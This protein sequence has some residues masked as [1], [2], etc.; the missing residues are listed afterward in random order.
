MERL[1]G[2]R[3]IRAGTGATFELATLGVGKLRKQDPKVLLGNRVEIKLGN[4]VEPRATFPHANANRLGVTVTASGRAFATFLPPKNRVGSSEEASCAGSRPRARGAE[5]L[6]EL[7]PA[8]LHPKSSC[9]ATSPPGGKGPSCRLV[10][11]FH[12]HKGETK[13]HPG[14]S[15][16]RIQSFA[17]GFRDTFPW[18]YSVSLGTQFP[19]MSNDL[20][21]LKGKIIVRPLAH[22]KCSTYFDGTLVGGNIFIIYRAPHPVTV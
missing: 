10:W 19:H 20:S 9:G 11:Q 15:L 5:T 22:S 8:P 17:L 6:A 1:E 4:D 2:G 16:S 3:G 21:I 12:S 14:W 13:S 7:L 18:S